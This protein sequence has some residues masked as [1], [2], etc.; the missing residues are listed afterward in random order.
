MPLWYTFCRAFSWFLLTCSL[1]SFRCLVLYKIIPVGPQLRERAT[2]IEIGCWFFLTY[3]VYRDFFQVWNCVA[4]LFIA[5]FRTSSFNS[6][7]LISLYAAVPIS[8]PITSSPVYGSSDPPCVKNQFLE[9]SSH[10]SENGWIPLATRSSSILCHFGMA[11][12]WPPD[13][14]LWWYTFCHAFY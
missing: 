1:P 6:S 11:H 14:V 9:H 4:I 8:P 7:L 10:S 13:P 3:F 12:L 2:S 5:H